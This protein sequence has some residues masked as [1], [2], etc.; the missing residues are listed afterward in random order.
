MKKTVV[1]E[2]SDHNEFSRNYL[3]DSVILEH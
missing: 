3:R 1:E 2:S